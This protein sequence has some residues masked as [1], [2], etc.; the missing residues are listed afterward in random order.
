MAERFVTLLH[1]GA[2]NQ[3]IPERPTQLNL[4][5]PANGIA[6]DTITFV[7]A[8]R[9]DVTIEFQQYFLAELDIPSYG[10]PY[11]HKVIPPEDVWSG[12]ASL[13]TGPNGHHYRFN[14]NQAAN[15]GNCG[16]DPGPVAAIT[17]RTQPGDDPQII[18]G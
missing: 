1:R 4:A 8:T 18:I 7:N 10:Q 6:G 2:R 13:A 9:Q 16:R 14:F 12:T 17:P 3:V 5:D 11:F 15:R